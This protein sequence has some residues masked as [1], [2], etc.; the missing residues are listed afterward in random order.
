LRLAKPDRT[1]ELV[2]G[3]DHV[4]ML[5]KPAAFATLRRTFDAMPR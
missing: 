4:D 1:V 5:M 2:P 3:L